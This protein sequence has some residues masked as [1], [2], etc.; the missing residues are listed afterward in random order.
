[1]KI[2][3]ERYEIASLNEEVPALDVIK[4]AESKIAQMTGKNVTLI[5][6]AETE[7]AK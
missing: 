7:Q 1:M 5:A 3:T 6:Y 4:E 2:D